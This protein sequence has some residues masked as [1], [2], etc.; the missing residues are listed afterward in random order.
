VN[1]GPALSRRARIALCIAVCVAC[2]L[3]AHALTFAF[4]IPATT[5][6]QM[7]D[8]AGSDT[9]ATG[10][11]APSGMQTR[12]VEGARDTTTY[13]IATPALTTLQIIAPLR[14]QL[15][16]AGFAVLFECEAVACG[17]FD[18]RYGLNILPE[19]DMHVDI[20]DYRYLSAERA[21]PAG[22]EVIGIIVS[23]SSN[24]G[25][26]QISRVGGT[27]PPAGI[28]V[29]TQSTLP[30]PAPV[31]A[32]ASVPPPAVTTATTGDIGARLETGGALALDDL[33]FASGDDRLDA[34]DYASLGDLAAYLRANPDA[35]VTFV[36]HTDA[37]GS[38][39][40]NITLSQG[41]AASVRRA[42]ID[43]YNIPAAQMSA[44]GVGYLSP[45]ASNRTEAGRAANRRVEVMLT[46][47]P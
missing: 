14:D 20:G 9:I 40:G 18:F 10:P 17:G 7:Q 29:S 11:W 22:V 46:I 30:V 44:E 28:S 4:P 1:T 47:T 37:S 24:A 16:G 38:L 45:R 41:R 12:T 35:R 39:G 15:R 32:P 19:P 13:R 43:T 5:L 34:R 8:P 3:P 25:F 26:V 21:G 42:M 33:V 36:G 27:L 31:P 23:R 2:A 6:A